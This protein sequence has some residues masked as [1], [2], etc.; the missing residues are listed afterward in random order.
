MMSK[1][2]KAELQDHFAFKTLRSVWHQPIRDDE[3][4]RIYRV[5][6]KKATSNEFYVAQA[7]DDLGYEFTFQLAIAG[8]KGQAF[9]IVL[10]FFVKTVPRNTPVWVHG[11]HW[12]MGARR[13]KDIRQQSLVEQE[14]GGVGA[15]NPPVEIWGNDSGNK[16]D[17]V[18]AVRRE[19]R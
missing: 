11:E 4:Q 8:G 14:M 3:S 19:M 18:K 2:R 15:L 5:Q 12:H 6:G 10:D 17:A 1:F 9:G 16:E 13:A 7:F